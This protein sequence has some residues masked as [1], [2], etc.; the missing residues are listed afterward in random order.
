MHVIFSSKTPVNID[1]YK[2]CLKNK[3]SKCAKAKDNLQYY[4]KD[5]VRIS[6][7]ERKEYYKKYYNKNKHLLEL[8]RIKN[9]EQKKQYSKKYS[10]INKEKISKRKPNYKAIGIRTY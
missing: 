10:K 3:F 1:F 2:K 9:K 5:C 8:Y 6:Y 4:C 7:Q